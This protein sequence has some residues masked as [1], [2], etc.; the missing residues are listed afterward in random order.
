AAPH[1]VLSGV[2]HLQV[3]SPLTDLEDPMT[4]FLPVRRTGT[5]FVVAALLTAGAVTATSLAARSSASTTLTAAAG[6]SVADTAQAPELVRNAATVNGSADMINLSPRTTAIGAV[7]SPTGTMKDFMDASLDDVHATWVRLFAAR[8]WREPSVS[9]LWPSRGESYRH[10]N[11]CGTSDDTA[12]YYCPNDDTIVISQ[13]KA[14]AL[15]EGNTANGRL[16]IKGTGD[17]SVSLFIAHEYGHNVAN[18]FGF[19][20]S[21]ALQE[22]LADCFAGV[23]AVDAARRGILEEGDVLEAWQVLDLL[24][25]HAEL[26]VS[27]NGVHG[28]PADRQKAFTTGWEGGLDSCTTA[29]AA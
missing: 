18:E 1:R 20:I 26:G 23:W 29:Y 4:T 21:D 2:R 11:A 12:L 14:T 3:I 17:M 28:T 9:Y 15:W 13:I 25:E 16:T 6:S 22:R 24:A 7:I 8:N 10:N 5:A 27:D 19:K